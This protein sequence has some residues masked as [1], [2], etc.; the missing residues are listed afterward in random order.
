[1]RLRRIAPP[2]LAALLALSACTTVRGGPPAPPR[3]G[4]APAGELSSPVSPVPPARVP[5]PAPAREELAETGPG[6][7]TGT[8]LGTAPPPAAK[9]PAGRAA[10]GAPYRRSP[11]RE[12]TAGR[13]RDTAREHTS[14]RD[15]R[16]AGTPRK[17]RTGP[18]VTR[19]LPR[20]S[21]S[22]RDLCRASHGVADPAIV[23]LCHRAYG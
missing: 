22:M 18:A 16:P 8:G 12:R 7:E 9:K 17:K 19:P 20:Q 4:L 1:M 14:E 2:V 21:V 5:S 15:R 3:P 11:A 6:T 23:S 13:V 10:A